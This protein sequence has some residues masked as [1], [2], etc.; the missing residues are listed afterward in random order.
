MSSGSRGLIGEMVGFV[1]LAL[2]GAAALLHYGDIK[3]F[4]LS[5]AGVNLPGEATAASISPAERRSGTVEISMGRNGHFQAEAEVNGRSIDVMVDTGAT[6]V[7]LTYEDAERAGIYVRD[8]DFTHR[9]NTANGT[10]R[11]APVTIERISIGDI[12][13]RNVQGAVME[14][15][16]LNKTLLGMA[17]LGRLGRA[18]MKKGVLVLE[19]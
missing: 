10:G 18:E 2:L 3:R 5:Q 14:S 9:V 11:V 17:F 1:L 16:K 12:T 6:L 8:S 4:M 13:V 19:E 7:A 15:G